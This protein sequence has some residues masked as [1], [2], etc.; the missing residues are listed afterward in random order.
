MAVKDFCTQI[1][2]IIF[3]LEIIYLKTNC[4]I[5]TVIE[6]QNIINIYII[7]SYISTHDIYKNNRKKPYLTTYNYIIHS[8]TY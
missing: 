7:Y 1:V 2:D 3:L 5:Y 6:N 8:H 4:I